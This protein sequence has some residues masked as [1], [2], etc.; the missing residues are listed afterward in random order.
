[1]SNVP[2]N[3]TDY[4]TYYGHYTIKDFAKSVNVD[5]FYK[6]CFVRNPW[7]RMLS[8]Y[9][10]SEQFKA[11]YN[12]FE[13]FVHAVHKYRHVYQKLN[14][15]WVA[16][17]GGVPDL[18][19]NMPI[20]FLKTQKSFITIENNIKMDFIGKHENLEIDWR[21]LCNKMKNYKPLVLTQSQWDKELDACMLPHL[22][23]S[24][25]TN[26]STHTDKH[27]KE[28]YTPMLI[29]LVGEIY[30]DDV[31]EFNYTFE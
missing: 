5:N 22:R 28:Y 29:D 25:T 9:D 8:S 14:H 27:W 26:H 21:Q 3:K 10:H 30:Q 19:N 24:K 17:E 15:E 11:V 31:K 7:S 6:W 4:Y 20:I 2:W 18:T 13:K 23:N 12:T 1:M 16:I